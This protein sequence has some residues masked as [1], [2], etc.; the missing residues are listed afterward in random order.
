MASPVWQYYKVSEKD[1][2]FVVCNVRGGTHQRGF[3]T[4][5]LIRHL[6]ACHI[7]EFEG[8]TKLASAKAEKD[9]ER[10]TSSQTHSAD[11]NRDIETTATIQQRQQ[12]T[13]GIKCKGNLIHMP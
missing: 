10:A 5:K 13:K 1:N 9:N 11:R 12:E 7:N 8:F 6:K 3:N 2:K 4:T